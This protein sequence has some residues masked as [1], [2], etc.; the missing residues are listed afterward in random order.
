M[1]LPRKDEFFAEYCGKGY[2]PVAVTGLLRILLTDYFSNPGNIIKTSLK[3]RI[4]TD[5]DTT[6]ILIESAGLWKPE[7]AG[8]RPAI[9][10]NRGEWKFRPFGLHVGLVQGSDPQEFSINVV[11]SHNIICIAKTV[12]ET[13]NLAEEVARFLVNVSPQ[14]I[15]EL[16]FLAFRVEGV[17][18]VKYVREDRGHYAAVVTVVYS[19]VEKWT[20]TRTTSTTP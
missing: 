16:P 6:E 12:A 8:R 1:A 17:S 7:L 14:I 10:I 15:D 2:G 9:L 4:F 20:I 13:E 5:S 3:D 18:G 11:G 19:F